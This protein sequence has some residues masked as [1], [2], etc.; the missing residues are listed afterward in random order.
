MTGGA[1]P[2][3][4][5]VPTGGDAPGGGFA[6]GGGM[7]T[8]GGATGGA[9]PVGGAESGGA[10][11]SGGSVTGGSEA[12]SEAGG[13]AIGGAP[14]GG[15]ESGGAAT[16]G[17][18]GSSGEDCAGPLPGT[19]GQNPLFTDRYTADPAAFV[20]GCTFY[21]ACGHDEGSTGFVM[22][23]WYLLS[24]TDLVTWTDN[25]GPALS[26]DDFAWA[27][28]NAWAGHVTPRNGRFYW[29]VP[30]NQRGGAMT[31]G[32]AVADSPT[33]P[34][35]DAIGAPLVSD[36]IEMENWGFTDAGQ[37]PYTIDP[38]VFVDDDGQAY[39]YYGGFWR[40]VGGRLGDDMISLE[41]D[42]AELRINGAPERGN[43]WEAPYV[44]KRDGT[45]TLIYAA[46]ENPATIDYATATDPLGP[47]SYRG[48]I[49]GQLP[50]VAGQDAAT[51]HAGVAEFLGDWYLVYHV[52]DGPNGGG[53]YRRE[54]AI[55]R[56]EFAG[57]GSI[58]TITP[59]AGLVF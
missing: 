38:A 37:T 25:G 17:D 21:V 43:Y 24:S 58:P 2:T 33:G 12:G 40:L 22:R 46:G 19:S 42:L 18:G 52:S 15:G 11:A 5:T 9:A 29:Y 23:D 1:F 39:L 4:G 3:G 54:V 6:T 35:E 13:E 8:G 53:T 28:A 10:T 51:N 44:I 30:I 57:D 36:P 45:Y 16:G 48:R 59:S 47:F 26:L 14:T 56:F 27:D 7:P 55:E 32:V 34:Y 49:L 20:H 50:N 31:I 41:G